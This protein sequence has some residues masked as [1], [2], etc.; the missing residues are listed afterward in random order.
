LIFVKSIFNSS[1]LLV[2]PH[3]AAVIATDRRE[4]SNLQTPKAPDLRS[5]VGLYK[6][7]YI[8]DLQRFT[9]GG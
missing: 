8:I 1:G 5:E 4:W 9:T 7:S 3:K 6:F 2:T